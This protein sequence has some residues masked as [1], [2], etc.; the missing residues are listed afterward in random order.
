MER[1][2]FY[3]VKDHLGSIRQTLD[4]SGTVYSALDYYAFGGTMVAAGQ[5]CKYKFTGKGSDSDELF[6]VLQTKRKATITTA[7]TTGLVLFGIIQ[8]IFPHLGIKEILPV[9]QPMQVSM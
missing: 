3:Y 2:R 6:P 4:E 1:Q 9:H 8:E 7:P 5:G